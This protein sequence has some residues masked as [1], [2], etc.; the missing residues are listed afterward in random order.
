MRLR[1]PRSRGPMLAL[2]VIVVLLVVIAAL[3][4]VYLAPR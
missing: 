3:Y 1:G 4:I 2:A